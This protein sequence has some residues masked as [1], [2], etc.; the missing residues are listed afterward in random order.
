MSNDRLLELISRKLSGEA[1]VEELQEIEKILSVD[2]DAS[3]S[4][5]LLQQYWDQHDNANQ[6]FVEEAFGKILNRLDLPVAAPVVEMH[7][8]GKRSN[9]NRLQRIAVGAAIIFI[10]GSILIFK[11]GGK[12]DRLTKQQTAL[13]E[14]KNSKGIKSTIEL[15]DGSKVWLNADSK[16]QFPKVFTGNTREVYLSGEA[17][18]EVAKNASRPFIIH[19]AN[20]T[21]KVL[22]TSFNIRAYDNEKIIEASVATGKVAFIPYRKSGKKQDTVFLTSD[23]KVRYLFTKE[24][25]IV[26]PTVSKEDRA[27]ITGKLIFKAMTFEEIGMQLERNFGKK[28]VFLSDTARMFRLTGSFQNNSLEEILFYLSKSKE[29]N[30]KITDVEVLIS[31]ESTELPD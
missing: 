20:G 21:V 6:F 25:T 11:T 4:I 5:K 22:G 31:D 17:F 8:S 27:W 14:K 3:A 19:L 1:T 12:K 9:K 29:F 23:N 28:I 13:I 2:T 16:I 24:E 7:G 26:E 18:F 30:Y 10:A 15:T